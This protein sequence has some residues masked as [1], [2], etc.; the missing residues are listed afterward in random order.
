[1]SWSFSRGTRPACCT[2]SD[3]VAVP[4]RAGTRATRQGLPWGPGVASRVGPTTPKSSFAG[5]RLVALRLLDAGGCRCTAWRPYPRVASQ[6][7]RSSTRAGGVHRQAVPAVQCTGARHWV[8][9]PGQRPTRGRCGAGIGYL[10][11]HA[12]AAEQRS[13]D[14]TP[15]AGGRGSVGSRAARRR[16]GSLHRYVH[17]ARLRACCAGNV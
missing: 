1:L 5:Q 9:G 7:R 4:P 14:A 8:K 10:K 15:G 13:L 3:V 17:A 16:V 2:A 11:L 12:G 6:W